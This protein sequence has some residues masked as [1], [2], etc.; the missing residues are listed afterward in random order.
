M[1]TVTG[2]AALPFS[3]CLLIN[4]PIPGE[5][6]VSFSVCVSSQY[7]S[8]LNGM[9]LLLEEEILSFKSRPELQIRG[10][11]EDN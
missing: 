10:G 11:I 6:T 1:S 9:N 2:E 7:E 5:V 3:F 4:G 8:I